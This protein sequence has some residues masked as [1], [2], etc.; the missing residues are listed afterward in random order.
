MTAKRGFILHPCSYFKNPFLW[1][2][3]FLYLSELLLFTSDMFLLDECIKSKTE[4]YINYIWRIWTPFTVQKLVALCPVFFLCINSFASVLETCS[5]PGFLSRCNLRPT[6]DPWSFPMT[7]FCHKLIYDVSHITRGVTR[8]FLVRGVYRV[9]QTKGNKMPKEIECR[10]KKSMHYPPN[11]GYQTSENHGNVAKLHRNF[12]L[13]W[14]KPV[15]LSLK[16]YFWDGI[17]E[18]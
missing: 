2:V 3:W 5:S 15:N 12:S 16:K 6:F 7:T 18:I 10:E 17:K 14:Y 11:Y 9:L 13:E 8:A 4:W 1:Y